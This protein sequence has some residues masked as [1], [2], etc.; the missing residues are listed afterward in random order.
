MSDRLVQEVA[1]GPPTGTPLDQVEADWTSAA[2]RRDRLRA[3]LELVKAGRLEVA[4]PL[5]DELYAGA[6]D[7]ARSDDP[8]ELDHQSLVT[9]LLTA[10]EAGSPRW[11]SYLGRSGGTVVEMLACSGSS[12]LAA[13]ALDGYLELALA[14]W[15]DAPATFLR[16][17]IDSVVALSGVDVEEWDEDVDRQAWADRARA[18]V[19]ASSSAYVVDGRPLSAAAVGRAAV[20]WTERAVARNRPA[21]RAD[22]QLLSTWSGVM[23]PVA[24]LG[25]PATTADV[26]AVS[27]YVEHVLAL[28]WRDGVKYFYSHDVD[29]GPGL[30][31]PSRAR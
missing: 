24:P 18:A 2:T 16:A 4:A 21:P 7:L 23:G 29:G 8:I 31:G 26:Q 14:W 20:E 15:D 25:R 11:R 17:A 22:L 30:H 12:V 13:S 3:G 5:R 19:A 9:C 6:G 1:F 27:A 10:D 28:P